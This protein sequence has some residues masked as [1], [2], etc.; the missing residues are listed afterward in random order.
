MLTGRLIAFDVETT[1]LD[2]F[3]DQLLLIQLGT[4]TKRIVIDCRKLGDGIKKLAPLLG[5]VDF[6]KLGH[7]IAFDCAFLEVNGLR[8]RG[9]LVDTWLGSKVD[10]AGLPERKGMNSLEGC[11]K[12]LLGVE[13]N[14]EQ[15]TSFIDFDGE[16]RDE[17]LQYAADDVG[18]VIF[19]V[20]EAMK[21]LLAGQ[22]LLHVWQLECR[23]LPA[24]IQ[25]RINGLKLDIDYYKKLFVSESKFR[26]KKKLEVVTHLDERGLLND[27]KCPLTGELLIH[28]KCSGKGD[29]KVK[30][31][32]LGSPLQLGVV[33]AAYGVPLKKKVN[34]ESGKVSYSCDKNIIAFYLADFEIL[35]IY[36]EFKEAATACSYVEKLIDF[37]EKS[38]DGRIHARYNPL[39]RTGRASC[40]EPN[41]QQIKKGPE[42]RQGFVSETG[43]LLINADYSQ[44]ELRVVTEVSGDENLIEIYEKGLD[45][46]T[47]SASLMTGVP[48]EEVSKEARS[49]AKVFNFSCL[50]GA[51]AKTVRRQ[52]VSQFGLMWSLE[53][54]TEK[55]QSWKAAYPG[56]IQW[57]RKQGNSE[58]L[59]V[60]TQFG[61][62]RLLQRPKRGESNFTTNLN[63]P[64]QGL[65]ADCMK[66]A[67]ALLWEQYLAHD[68]EI[69]IC[70]CIHDEVILEAPS[71]RA[72]EAEKMLKECMEDAAPLVG[73]TTVPIIAEPSSGRSW[74]ETK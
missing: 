14:K 50:Y 61:R 2:P 73:I 6:G 8:V 65:G 22:D 13:L 70:A 74:A 34:E 54:V 42:H 43:S 45:V 5:S 7:N 49:A 11:A 29:D 24:F 56:L 20:Y 38:P 3:H 44:L 66:A 67:L 32:N 69:K 51:G 40:S 58:D 12:R 41:L 57:Q 62:R 4:R 68:P 39:V 52:A 55:L 64:I 72:S 10:T 16:F 19:D 1:G 71:Y 30:G 31:F 59:E 9:P 28:P 53:E 17:Q 63:T 37:A 60:F 27:Y 48:L 47:A 46:H 33:L 18:D 35:R 15:Q 23:A 26:E 21:K 36:K 25:M